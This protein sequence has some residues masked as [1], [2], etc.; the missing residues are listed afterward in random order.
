[1][2]IPIKIILVFEVDREFFADPHSHIPLVHE[3]IFEST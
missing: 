3:E 2:V 1:M